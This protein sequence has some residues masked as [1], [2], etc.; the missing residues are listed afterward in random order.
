MRR[1]VHINHTIKL[2][3]RNLLVS[4]YLPMFINLSLIDF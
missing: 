3:N 2:K 1:L 4:N